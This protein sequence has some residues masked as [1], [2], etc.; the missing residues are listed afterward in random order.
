[1]FNVILFSFIYGIFSSLCSIFF[2]QKITI[3]FLGFFN[4]EHP[5]QNYIMFSKLFFL[6]I[7]MSV[8]FFFAFSIRI[9]YPIFFEESLRPIFI[10]IFFSTYFIIFLYFLL[11]KID[12]RPNSGWSIP[13]KFFP[14]LLDLDQTSVLYSYRISIITNKDWLNTIF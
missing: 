4:K 10:K 9:A 3:F 8:S 11:E 1:M 7:F 6:L 12:P 2:T 14:I 13:S 5:S